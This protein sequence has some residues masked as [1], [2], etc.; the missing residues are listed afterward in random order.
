MKSFALSTTLLIF[1]GLFVQP[2]VAIEGGP[3][4]LKLGEQTVVKNG[5]GSRKKMMLSLYDGT[6]YLPQK[7]SDAKAIVQADQPMAVHIKITSRF[8]SQEKMVAALNDGFK[9][10]TRGNTAAINDDIT[11]FK[12]CFA[13]PI[14][15]N[16][17]FILAYVPKKGVVVFKNNQKKGV[18]GDLAFK[19]SLFGIWL[20]QKPIDS[21]MKTAML[22]K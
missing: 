15:M 19:K 9:A 14:K 7:S 2:V 5:V 12:A 10:S 13:E 1:F 18:V 20:G 11:K 3:G 4:S 17:V 22:G 8:V 21:G 6:L 16:D